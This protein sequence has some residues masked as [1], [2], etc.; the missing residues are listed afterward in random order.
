[1]SSALPSP[2]PRLLFANLPARHVNSRT[3]RALRLWAVLVICAVLLFVPAWWAIYPHV[4]AYSM[5]QQLSA[6]AKANP[7]A[8]APICDDEPMRKAKKVCK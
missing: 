6:A 8:S 5:E 1:M 3:I 2:K 7:P 4:V